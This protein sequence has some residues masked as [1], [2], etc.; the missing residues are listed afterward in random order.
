M[1]QQCPICNGTGKIHEPLSTATHSVCTVCQGKK[2]ISSLTGNPP[3]FP[4][5]PTKESGDFRDDNMESQQEY[6]GK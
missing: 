1:W 3:P 5:I 6:F 2:I 4:S